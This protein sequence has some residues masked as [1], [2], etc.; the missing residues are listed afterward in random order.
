L[1]VSGVEIFIAPYTIG[2]FTSLFR[3]LQK[4]GHPYNG[5]H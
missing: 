1:S 2:R 3:A 5:R 4:A